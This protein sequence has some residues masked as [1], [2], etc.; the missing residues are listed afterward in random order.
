[1]KILNDISEMRRNRGS[2]MFHQ[3][4]DMDKE[5]SGELGN[6]GHDSDSSMVDKDVGYEKLL[7][8]VKQ[9]LFKV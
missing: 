3:E 4:G 5:D 7:E 2:G 1:M 6:D 8:Q 9:E